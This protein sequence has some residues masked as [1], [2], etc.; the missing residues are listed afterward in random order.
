VALA[1]S[2]SAVAAGAIG[3]FRRAGTAAEPWR[4]STALVTGGVY[5]FTRNPMYLA[6]VLLH[7]GLALA[8]DSAVALALLP[9]LLALVQAGVVLREERYLERR[10][11]DEYR[12]YRASVRRWL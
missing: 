11:G 5:R 4:P 12:R 9:S 1:A 7:L 10:F 6:M 2:A 8:V 3:R